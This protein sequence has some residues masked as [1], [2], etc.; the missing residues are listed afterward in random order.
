L[1][2]LVVDLGQTQTTQLQ[3]LVVQVD[4]AEEEE[5]EVVQVYLVLAEQA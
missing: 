1:L 4:Q 2:H 5:S 3:F